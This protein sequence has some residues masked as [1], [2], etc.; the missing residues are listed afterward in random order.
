MKIKSMETIFPQSA[1]GGAGFD[2]IFFAAMMPDDAITNDSTPHA[3]AFALVD[4]MLK[5]AIS[6][7]MQAGDLCLRWEALAWLWVCCPDI[8]D[9]LR[10]P[11]PEAADVQQRATAYMDRYAAF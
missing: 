8:A 4:E 7:V 3:T 9:Q 1:R 10:L 5:R 6:D 2:D 11:G